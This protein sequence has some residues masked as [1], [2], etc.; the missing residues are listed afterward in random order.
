[1]PPQ[2]VDATQALN[3]SIVIDSS[4]QIVLNTVNFHEYIIYLESIIKTLVTA[5]QTPVILGSN[6]LR[7]CSRPVACNSRTSKHGWLARNLVN[8]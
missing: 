1:M 8:M 5:F 3:L 2:T 6:R 7:C 4:P